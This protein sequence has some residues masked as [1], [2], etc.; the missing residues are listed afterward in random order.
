MKAISIN[1]ELIE[2]FRVNKILAFR[3]LKQQA[4]DAAEAGDIVS[5]A[6]MSKATVADTIADQ[7]VEDPIP[8]QP[9]DPPTITVTFVI[10]LFPRHQRLHRLE[11]PPF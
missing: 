9:I 1:N 2:N 8:A 10:H 7:S 11:C 6:G 4:I 3:G 5:L